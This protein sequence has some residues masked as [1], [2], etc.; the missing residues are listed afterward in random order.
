MIASEFTR[1][2]ETAL[3]A[4][5]GEADAEATLS[6]PSHSWDPQIQNAIEQLLNS[7]AYVPAA[8]LAR[9]YVEQR[10]TGRQKSP[11]DLDQFLADELRLSPDL[12]IEDLRRL[13]RDF[14]IYNHPDRVSASER[15]LATRRMS[16]VN[17]LI[18]KALKEKAVA[19]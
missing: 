13:R 7:P 9:M 4:K 2:L 17:A 11:Q 14:A 16:L 5:G 6:H 15:A 8:E 1:I 19:K 10:G 12:S 18:D 3:A